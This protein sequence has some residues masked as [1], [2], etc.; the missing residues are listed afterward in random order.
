MIPVSLARFP[1]LGCSLSSIFKEANVAAHEEG[2]GSGV[3]A[4]APRGQTLSA[5]HTAAGNL[6]F[7]VSLRASPC[8]FQ[9]GAG[10]SPIRMA[11]AQ[12]AVPATRTRLP[13]RCRRPT[14]TTAASAT[15]A[16]GDTGPRPT[17]LRT[18]TE[19]TLPQVCEAANGALGGRG[20][21]G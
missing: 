13:C 20:G 8:V 7:G 16:S 14:P 21:W 18:C 10:S 4:P 1:H 19:T 9:W 5:A 3:V 11:C 6:V 2:G 12:Q 17:L 15:P